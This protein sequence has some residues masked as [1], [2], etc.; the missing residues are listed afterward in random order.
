[1]AY[2]TKQRGY[3]ARCPRCGLY[4]VTCED[5]GE[6]AT[7]ST[8]FSDWLRSASCPPELSSRSFDAQNLDF[9]WFNYR[10]GWFILLEEKQSGI[11]QKRNQQDTHRI[12]DQLIRIGAASGETVSTWRGKRRIEYRGYYQVTFANTTPDDSE[13][14]EINGKRYTRATFLRLLRTGKVDDEA[15]HPGG[16][17]A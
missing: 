1:M 17:V 12:V 4:P 6:N 5:C 8:P 9:I 15:A 11:R 13:W 14:I 7:G 2:Q 3:Y 10:E 16:F